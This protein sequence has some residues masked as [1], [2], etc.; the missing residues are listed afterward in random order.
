MITILDPFVRRLFSSKD[1]VLP[2]Q[3]HVNYGW[4]YLS[5][6]KVFWYLFQLAS[7]QA[8]IEKQIHE[9]QEEVSHQDECIKQL[10]KQ[11]KDAEILLV[12]KV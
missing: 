10:Q 4:H 3:N 9:L 12:C 5:N 11:F 7:E 1:Y 2:L 8:D 6:L